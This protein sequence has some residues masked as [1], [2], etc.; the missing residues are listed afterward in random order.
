MRGYPSALNRAG[1][2]FAQEDPEV[3]LGYLDEGIKVARQLSDGWFW[4]ANLVEFIELCYRIWD[5]SRQRS[6]LDRIS[7]RVPEIAQA[8]DEY[9]FPDLKGRW[10]LVRGHLSLS[11]WLED[12][13]DVGLLSTAL[14]HYKE[15]FAQIAQQYVGSSG[16]ATIASEF[17]KFARLVWLLPIEIRATWQ[18]EFRRA[19]AITPG[20]TLLLARLELLY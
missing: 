1:R 12:Q 14:R 7:S 11:A 8:M 17:A 18:E 19:W 5:E 15:G 10:N 16:A 4:F 6:Y 13:D 3:G 9:E 20:S 2:I